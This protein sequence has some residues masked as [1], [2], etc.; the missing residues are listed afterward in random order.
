M[1]SY[2]VGG[3]VFAVITLVAVKIIKDKMNHK[4]SCANC[5]GC[6]A[7]SACKSNQK[8]QMQIEE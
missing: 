8:N 6:G 4:S 3:I 5:S 7:A 1:A 2:I